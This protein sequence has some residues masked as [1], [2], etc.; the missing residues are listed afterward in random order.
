M[1][2]KAAWS[3]NFQSYSGRQLIGQFLGS[4]A[5]ISS[6]FSVRTNYKVASNRLSKLAGDLSRLGLSLSVLKVQGRCKSHFGS[7]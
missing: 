4:C 2:L 5:D 6:E 3:T 7:N 1:A